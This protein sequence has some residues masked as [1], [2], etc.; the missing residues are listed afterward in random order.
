[1][2]LLRLEQFPKFSIK[3]SKNRWADFIELFCLINMDKE[4]SLND[5]I[6]NYMQEEISETTDGD[7]LYSERNMKL[8]SEFL[9]IFRYIKSR[10]NIIGEFYPFECIDMDTIKLLS[11]DDK[12]ILYIYFLFSSN[13]SYFI[14]RTIP[15]VF[16]ASFERIS[17][18][19]MKVIYPNF[20][21]ELF[22]TANTPGG[23]FYGGNLLDK[24]K[25]LAQCLNTA[26]KQPATD[27]PHNLS[28][29]GDKG[30][31]IVSFYN[32]D[33]ESQ[34]APFIPL[35]MGQCSCSYDDWKIK[36]SS[37]KYSIWNNRFNDLPAY[38]EYMFV[39][40]PLRGIEGGWADEEREEIQ[41]I[42]VDRF[43]F[44]SLLKIDAS[45]A[46]AILADDIKEQL[47]TCLGEL[48]VRVN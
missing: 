33:A 20:R 10:Q 36:Q 15:P 4:I 42:I 30:L 7:E 35:C 14:D 31:D 18:Q 41:T 13:T 43:R 23:F 3:L 12:K 25:K 46:A 39:P 11:V 1:M 17:L 8:R 34:Q 47:K 48:N 29:G 40:F 24:L 5:I 21:N 6:T 38:H 19:F 22:G 32:L 27:N 37:I 2:A 45:K 28:T 44:F 16:T 9:E 26:L